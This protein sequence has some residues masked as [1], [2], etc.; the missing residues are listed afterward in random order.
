MANPGPTQK[1]L[2]VVL[3]VDDE[4]L[5]I[6]LVSEALRETCQ[7]YTAT[8]AIEAEQ[9]LPARHYDVIVCDHMLSGEQGL[10]FLT[11]VMEM[12][13][14]TRRILMTGYT[15]PE[16]IARSMSIAGLSNCLVKPLGTTEIADAIRAALA[17]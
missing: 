11:R 13:P 8:S 4:P 17:A 7:L 14:S 12:I 5:I 2:P 9:I 15:N 6:A 1:P 3:I 16:F 10:D